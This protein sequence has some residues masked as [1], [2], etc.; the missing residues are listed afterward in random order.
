[1]NNGSVNIA[2]FASS[3]DPDFYWQDSSGTFHQ[4]V[5]SSPASINPGGRGPRA[6]GTRTVLNP[7][8]HLA[9]VR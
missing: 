1:M 5:V 4:E 3:G 2:V 8:L 6:T 9:R 7:G